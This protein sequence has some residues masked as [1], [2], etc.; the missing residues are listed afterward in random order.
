MAAYKGYG[1][2]W[3]RK[4]KVWW[5]AKLTTRAKRLVRQSDRKRNMRGWMYKRGVRLRR[6]C[7]VHLEPLKLLENPLAGSGSTRICG[8][9]FRTDC[10]GSLQSAD[11]SE[12]RTHTVFRVRSNKTRIE[13][14]SS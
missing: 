7:F 2:I 1:V 8:S 3:W 14:V 5:S 12:Q 10:D 9:R 6:H 4:K 13:Y 11:P